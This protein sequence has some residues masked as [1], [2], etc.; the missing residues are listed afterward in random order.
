PAAAGGAVGAGGPPAEA[1]VG[2]GLT[3][4]GPEVVLGEPPGSGLERPPVMTLVV[5]AVVARADRLPPPLV[6]LV[7][8]HGSLE[9]VVEAHGGLP[10]KPSQLL[11]GQR[12]AAVVAG[13]VSHKLDQLGI[14][15]R[16]L[17]DPLHDVQVLA[18]V[19]AP[20][21]VRL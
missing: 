5:G 7:P 15:A 9:T 2:P 17:D 13:P 6:P 12:V 20:A 4:P 19:G 8:A 21:V 11:R 16:Q 14:G 18:L 1:R 3:G 10:A